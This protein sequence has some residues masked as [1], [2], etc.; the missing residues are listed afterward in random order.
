MLLMKRAFIYELATNPGRHN[1]PFYD[2]IDIK[3]SALL[4]PDEARTFAARLQRLADSIDGNTCSDSPPASL[5]ERRQRG[6]PCAV[7]VVDGCPDG[8]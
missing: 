7:T 4:S 5:K 2:G 1:P 6:L 3:G 8:Y